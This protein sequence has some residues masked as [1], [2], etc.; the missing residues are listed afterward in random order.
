MN[1]NNQ[2]SPKDLKLTLGKN[3]TP[4]PTYDVFL[5]RGTPDYMEVQLA[6]KSETD[7]EINVHVESIF[8]ISR[9]AVPMFARQFSKYLQEIIDK[10]ET[11]DQQQD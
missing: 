4:I 1:E 5:I 7:T 9:N 8:R 6:N 11:Q 3:I 2:E 10:Q